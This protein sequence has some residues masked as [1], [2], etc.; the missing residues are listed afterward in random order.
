MTGRRLPPGGRFAL[1]VV[2]ACVL[3]AGGAV[4]RDRLRPPPVE[5]AD[6]AVSGELW[7]MPAEQVRSF[8]DARGVDG[9]T[10]EPSGTTVVA[11]VTW[12]PAARSGAYYSLVLGDT[13]GGAGVVD[14]V[15][16]PEPDAVS[17]GSGGLWNDLM[18][19]RPELRGNRPVPVGGGYTDYYELA[20]VPASHRGDVWLVGHVVNV[21][22]SVPG[23]LVRSVA[24]D[25]VLVLALTS[26]DRVWWDR[27]VAGG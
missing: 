14:E 13:R 1:G 10:V 23:D 24:P 12:R 26:A 16:G 2:L 20:A 4:A 22:A 9:P 18:A 11:R 19:S 7:T 15:I 21:A 5:P 8:L 25:P 17:R 3:L 27:R 6:A